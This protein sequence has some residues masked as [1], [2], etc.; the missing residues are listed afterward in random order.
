MG[1]KALV[2]GSGAGGSVAAMVLA[3][4]RWDVTIF[5][6]GANYFTNLDHRR[7]PGRCSPTTS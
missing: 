2:V 3:R 5:E 7:C 1:R 6:K 4:A